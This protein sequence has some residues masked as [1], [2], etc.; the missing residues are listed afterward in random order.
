[1]FITNQLIGVHFHLKKNDGMSVV[2]CIV[3]KWWPKLLKT[4]YTIGTCRRPVFSLGVSQ[5]MHI[6]TNLWTFELNW[7]SKLRDNNERKKIPLSHE[8]VCFLLVDFETSS[9]EL[10]VSKSNLW[11][12]TYFLENYVTSE[13]AVSHDVLYYQPL[14]ITR[15]QVRFCANNY[16]E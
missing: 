14:P 3:V 2:L 7:S 5:H 8:V 15:H 10:E 16:F 11:K 12:I 13:G 9:P 4:L 6:I 1:M